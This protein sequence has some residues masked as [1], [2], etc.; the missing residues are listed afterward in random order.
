MLEN[1][2]WEVFEQFLYSFM[3]SKIKEL[4][5]RNI[6]IKETFD[7]LNELS[8]KANILKEILVEIN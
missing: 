2:H 1:Y 4:I 5:T 7:I 6:M 8:D 3:S